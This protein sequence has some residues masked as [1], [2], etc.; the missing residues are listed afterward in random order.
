[1]GGKYWRDQTR[2]MEH[3][4]WTDATKSAATA[5]RAATGAKNFQK[6]LNSCKACM[7]QPWA[8]HPRKPVAASAPEAR[9]SSSSLW[10]G[11]WF[12]R[13]AATLHCPE[14]QWVLGKFGRSPVV[15]SGRMDTVA[16]PNTL[17]RSD[18]N[19]SSHP[20]SPAKIEEAPFPL[21]PPTSSFLKATCPQLFRVRK[22]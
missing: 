16:F 14:L 22:L 18:P 21:P 3:A 11:H 8:L 20:C 2:A 17:K 15:L 9:Y 19:F 1:M 6:R 10:E 7:A 4:D 5:T 13:P 12:Q